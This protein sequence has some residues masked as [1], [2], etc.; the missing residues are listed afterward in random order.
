MVTAAPQDQWR[1]LDVQDHDTRLSQIAHRRRNLPAH[2]AVQELRAAVARIGDQLV[3]ARTAA[4]DLERQVA[5]AETDVDLVRQRSERTSS[6]LEAGQGS[7]KDLQAMQHEMASLAQRQVVLEEVQLEVMERL[8]ASQAAVDRLEAE[9]EQTAAELERA[10]ADLERALAGLDA[11]A[12]IQIN[13]RA[14]AVAGVPED[15]RALYEKVREQTGGIA[16]ARLYQRRCE[17]CRLELN[18][19]DLARFRQSPIDTV[20][21]CEEC[22]RILV[23]TPE[24]GL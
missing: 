1:L 16:A 22:R 17:G 23:R 5:K 4:G 18:P 12:Q 2:G 3:S 13:A 20:L 6:R 21:R 7:S 11:E 9:R 14:D 24:S 8:E 15:L 10:S 19:T